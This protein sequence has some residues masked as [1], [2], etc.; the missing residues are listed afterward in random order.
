MTKR[1][2]GRFDLTAFIT[3]TSD[4]NAWRFI[5]AVLPPWWSKTFV[6]RN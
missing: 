1:N 4:F 5:V 3:D 2:R 6:P